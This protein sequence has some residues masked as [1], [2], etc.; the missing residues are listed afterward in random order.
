MST[1]NNSKVTVP[2]CL[3]AKAENR[4][5]VML[6]AYDH[7]MTKIL[8]E[9]GQVD[10]LLVGDSLGMVIQ[11]KNDTLSV[12]MDE[13][14]YHTSIVARTAKRAMVVADM[15]FMS[16]Q[17]TAYDALKNAGR[18][19]KEGGAH[20]IKLEGGKRVLNQVKAIVN[21]G[22]PVMG[23]LG[24]TPQSVHAF[25]GFKVQ[26]KSEYAVQQL[27]SDA[28][29]LEDAGVFSIVLEGIPTEAA[30]RITEHLKVPTIGIGAGS[31]CDGQVLVTYDMLGYSDS[32]P[33]FVKK[34]SL[35]KSII[36]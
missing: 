18:L 22:I 19:I 17:S 21:A 24:L 33:R 13:S 2:W 3:Q 12:T 30:R 1:L 27:I 20:A 9:T 15:P 10:I 6:T 34:Y 26:G 31:Y 28:I 29:A 23:H 7:L 16:F 11:G 36:Q 14:I 5:I 4:K 35:I 8:D 25:G 32:G